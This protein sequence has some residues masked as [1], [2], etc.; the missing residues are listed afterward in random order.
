MPDAVQI[1]GGYRLMWDS[2]VGRI[3]RCAKLHE[4]GAGTTEV[5]QLTAA[6]NSTTRGARRTD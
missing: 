6:R 1:H 3:C 4:I 5:R 2:Q